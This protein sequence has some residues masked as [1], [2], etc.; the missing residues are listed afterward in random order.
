MRIAWQS[1]VLG[2]AFAV[3]VCKVGR[4]DI[5]LDGEWRLDYFP[6]PDEGAVRALPL[7]VAFRTV[8]ATFLPMRQRR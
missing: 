5:C 8:R 7:D 4:S 1:V 3:M 2:L 6:Q